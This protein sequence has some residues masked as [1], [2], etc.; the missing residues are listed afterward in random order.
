MASLSYSISGFFSL[1]AKAIR[2]STLEAICK[3]LECQTYGLTHFKLS[4]KSCFMYK[5]KLK[6]ASCV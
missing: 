3:A 1:A 6:Y 2:L 4:L 5:K